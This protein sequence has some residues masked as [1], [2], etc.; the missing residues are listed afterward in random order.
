MDVSSS[1][2]SSETSSDDIFRRNKFN[3]DYSNLSDIFN[4]PGQYF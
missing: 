4:N 3:G 2:G 1:S